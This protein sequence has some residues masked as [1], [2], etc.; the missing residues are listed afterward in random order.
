MGVHKAQ[1]S[2]HSAV[3][4]IEPFCMATAAYDFF[5]SKRTLPSICGDDHTFR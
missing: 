3:C 2:L 4:L 5:I 1:M